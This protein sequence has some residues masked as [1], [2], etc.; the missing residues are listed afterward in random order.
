[1]DFENPTASQHNNGHTNALMDGRPTRNR[2]FSKRM[3]DSVGSEGGLN[4]NKFPIFLNTSQSNHCIG[5]DCDGK[6]CARAT[7][8]ATSMSTDRRCRS[9]N[10]PHCLECLTY[11]PSSRTDVQC[12]ECRLKG[13][14]EGTNGLPQNQEQGATDG[15]RT[16]ATSTSP[17][18]VLALDSMTSL[19][20]VSTT[21][22]RE[23]ITHDHHDENETRGNVQVSSH[24]AETGGECDQA[25]HI[26]SSSTPLFSH[27]V[28]Q[29]DTSNL[30]NMVGDNT[31]SP[32]PTSPRASGLPGSLNGT[33]VNHNNANADPPRG[34]AAG[35]A[36]SRH[37]SQ[38]SEV[39]AHTGSLNQNQNHGSAPSAPPRPSHIAT[40]SAEG[41]SGVSL[42]HDR[43]N[44]PGTAPATRLDRAIIMTH[45]NHAESQVSGINYSARD[46]NS[47]PAPMGPPYAP[48]RTVGTINGQ[49]YAP[50]PH[51]QVA[52]GDQPHSPTGRAPPSPSFQQNDGQVQTGSIHRIQRRS[53][54]NG[55][56]R[57]VT[58]ARVLSTSSL[59]GPRRA[60]NPPSTDNT[61]AG[62]HVLHAHT[63][64]N[65]RLRP[66]PTDMRMSSLNL[67]PHPR[68]GAS[69]HASS[70]TRMNLSAMFA[71]DRPPMSYAG[72]SIVNPTALTYQQRQPQKDENTALMKRIDKL[73]A[74]VAELAEGKAKERNEPS[75]RHTSDRKSSK[76]Q[77]QAQQEAETTLVL[78]NFPTFQLLSDF[79]LL[80][81]TFELK[82]EELG[83]VE[84]IRKGTSI[85]IIKCHTKKTKQRL[86]KKI[87]TMMLK[88]N[89]LS[90]LR[91]IPFSPRKQTSGSTSDTKST[92]R[93][94]RSRGKNQKTN[95][96]RTSPPTSED[97][98]NPSPRKKPHKGLRQDTQ[99]RSQSPQQ[100]P[101][102]GPNPKM[103]EMGKQI[104]DLTN[105]LHL[106][107]MNG[108]LHQQL[109]QQVSQQRSQHSFQPTL[110]SAHQGHGPPGLYLQ[111]HYS[112]APSVRTSSGSHNHALFL[113]ANNN[114]HLNRNNY[115]GTFP[116]TSHGYNHNV[117]NPVM[118]K[119]FFNNY[120]PSIDLSN[121]LYTHSTPP[122]R[123]HLRLNHNQAIP[124]QRYNHPFGLP[125][126]LRRN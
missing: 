30:H 115:G 48:Q 104:Q 78:K 87:T 68:S 103:Q 73:T 18:P 64:V 41:G 106:A 67:L 92:D 27:L 49:T 81:A 86:E 125:P 102:T 111:Q 113:A 4:V 121:R 75:S 105:T 35:S 76:N 112:S 33:S 55:A 32:A 34:Q 36:S 2:V 8:G 61:A 59:N 1:M 96:P 118:N 124:S 114:G 45:H 110:A 53:Y 71:P 17:T 108:R 12:A 38:P 93:R 37:D 63:G 52:C 94:P 19:S 65:T 3:N 70:L 97:G 120:Y 83:A 74:I 56:G 57:M 100:K 123:P 14:V 22:Q 80:K 40:V 85:L 46:P 119:D 43:T 10:R 98:S 77:D 16:S 29:G 66:E 6:R 9:C 21:A 99:R 82:K 62:S 109:N 90:S 31:P 79:D 25:H 89:R 69:S 95:R 47:T 11:T 60:A 126:H 24:R 44:N 20:Q 28:Q 23:E 72:A 54:G 88:K 117:N 58:P 42:A 122:P 116:I 50:R 101:S 51:G 7:D 91:I 26:T 84:V 15:S 107:Q 5:P 13:D 39:M